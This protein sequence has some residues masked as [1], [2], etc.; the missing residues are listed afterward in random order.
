MT[1]RHVFETVASELVYQG[2]VVALRA[3]DIRMPGGSV[4]RREVVE[5]YGAVAVAAV[6]D[7]RNIALIYQYRHPLGRRLWELPAGLLDLTGES[8]AVAANRE[9]QEETGLTARN[10]SVLVDVAASPGFTDEVVRVFLATGLT[11]LPREI[12][13]DDEEADLQLQWFPLAEAVKMVLSGEIVN[14]STI[15]GILAAQVAASEKIELRADDAQ[16][17]DRPSRFATRVDG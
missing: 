13:A 1:E 15:A 2:K 4:G 5:H 9:L 11:E 17:R 3:D 7:E 16:W 10:F 12:H 14:A 8:P 6:D